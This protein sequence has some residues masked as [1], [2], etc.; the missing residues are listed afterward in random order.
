MGEVPPFELNV[1]VFVTGA[2][3]TMLSVAYPSKLDSRKRFLTLAVSPKPTYT[4]LR[5]QLRKALF[6]IAVTVDGIV[7]YSSDVESANAY[8]SIVVTPDEI[9]TLLSDVQWS[10][11]CLPTVL[12]LPGIVTC[13]R[14]SQYLNTSLP[15]TPRLVDSV[16]SMMPVRKNADLPS[17]SN[18][19][20]RS[21][22]RR[23]TQFRKA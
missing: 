19:V 18:P 1:T 4:A 2:S 11:I 5:G 9:V 8:A 3:S 10:N 7:T 23:A 14:L 17:V 21:T 15:T 12:R 16:R 13:V 20:P 22:L 6:S